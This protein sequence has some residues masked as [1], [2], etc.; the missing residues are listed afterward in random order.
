MEEAASKGHIYAFIELA[1]YYEH[2]QRDAEVCIE[3]DQVGAKANRKIRFAG[4]YPKA[5]DGGITHRRQRLETKL[6]K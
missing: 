1:K 5:L 3:V 6:G 2:K 4:L